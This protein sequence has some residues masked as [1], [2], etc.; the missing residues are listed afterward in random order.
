MAKL[1]DCNVL[2]DWPKNWDVTEPVSPQ[3]VDVFDKFLTAN[4]ILKLLQSSQEEK[5][6]NPYVVLCCEFGAVMGHVLRQINPRLV[7]LLEHPYWDSSLFDPTSG[8]SIA[9][10]HWA[11]KK[12]SSYG[13]DD[14]YVAKMRACLQLLDK[15]AR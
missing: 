6:S 3:W 8:L 2:F 5:F 13:V 14:G 4:R 15:H 9:V 7:W 11:M 12:M 1:P 10:F